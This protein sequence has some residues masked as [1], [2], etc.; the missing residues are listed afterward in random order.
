MTL[1][2]PNETVEKL[3]LQI[4]AGTVID[5]ARD[6]LGIHLNGLEWV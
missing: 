4:K 2:P 5:G 1:S 3:Y 6:F